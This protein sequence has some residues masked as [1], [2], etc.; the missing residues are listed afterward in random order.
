MRRLPHIFV[1]N[2]LQGELKR[3]RKRNE[4]MPQDALLKKN[5]EANQIAQILTGGVK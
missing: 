3:S 4:Q 1:V 2:L 5:I